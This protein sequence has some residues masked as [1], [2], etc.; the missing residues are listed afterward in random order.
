M[1]FLSS[2]KWISLV[3]EGYSLQILCFLTPKSMN[4]SVMP[5][6]LPM[7]AYIRITQGAVSDF[8]PYRSELESEDLGGAPRNWH[9]SIESRTAV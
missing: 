3:Y 5:I 9:F 8:W 7:L 2:Y 4:S 1:Y 6:G